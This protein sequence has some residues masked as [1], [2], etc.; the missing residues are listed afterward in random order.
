MTARLTTLPLAAA[1]LVGR[2]P[3][4]RARDAST[5]LGSPDTTATPGRVRLQRGVPRRDGDRL[6][7][8]ALR[9]ASVEAPEDGVLVAAGVNAKRIAGIEAAADRGAAARRETA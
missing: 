9:G 3:R 8:F 2:A 6:R 4:R 7:Q 5:F 1:L